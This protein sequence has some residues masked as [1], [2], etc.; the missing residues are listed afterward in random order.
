MC[1]STN[2]T[3][4]AVIDPE[5]LPDR[6]SYQVSSYSHPDWCVFLLRQATEN[7]PCNINIS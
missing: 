4:H 5:G 1:A 6:Y 2:E 3:H 7:V